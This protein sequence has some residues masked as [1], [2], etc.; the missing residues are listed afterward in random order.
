M[1]PLEGEHEREPRQHSN[2][3]IACERMNCLLSG[4]VGSGKTLVSAISLVVADNAGGEEVLDA[5]IQTLIP[6]DLILAL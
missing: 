4:D 6:C 3:L 2:E 5:S 1:T